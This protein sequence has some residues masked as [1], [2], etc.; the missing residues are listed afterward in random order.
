[1]WGKFHLLRTLDVFI[2]QWK[3]FLRKSV[4]LEAAPTFYH[5][6]SHEFFKDVVKHEFQLIIS[7]ASCACQLTYDD[8]SGLRYVAGYV[9]RKL[10]DKLESSSIHHKTD[11]ILTLMEFGGKGLESEHASEEWMKALDRGG[12]WH[13]TDE[14]FYL[15]C[16]IEEDIRH[17]LTLL[18]ARHDGVK[19]DI[20]KSL[21]INEDVQ[22]L[23]FVLSSEL[24]DN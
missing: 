16:Y 15:F 19:R 14:V 17:H 9:C 7:H 5:F 20:I 21:K 10:L 3:D 18:S 8:E 23:W 24:D 4:G 22:N 12:L 13:V 6:I 1:M 11:M 2:L